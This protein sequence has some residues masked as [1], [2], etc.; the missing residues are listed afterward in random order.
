MESLL[1]AIV[2]L[3]LVAAL[4]SLVLPSHANQLLA[5]LAACLVFLCT[6]GASFAAPLP[7]RVG[8]LGVLRLDAMGAVFLLTVGLVYALAS[9][10]SAGSMGRER[11][12]GRFITYSRQ[13]YLLFHLFGGTMLVVPLLDNLAVLWIAIGVGLILLVLALSQST[14]TKPVSHR[15]PGQ[16]R[17]QPFQGGQPPAGR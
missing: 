2:I 15:V 11:T 5:V 16:G 13:Y 12:A 6:L 1:V 3:P 7:L 14:T 4:A 10:F 17:M 9:I 8:G